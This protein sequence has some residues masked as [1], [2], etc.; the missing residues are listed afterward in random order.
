MPIADFIEKFPALDIPFPED[1]VSTKA[2]RSEDGLAVFFTFH[3]DLDLPAHAHKGQWGTVLT[4]EIE[5]TID[6]KTRTYRPGEAYSIPSGAVHSARIPAGTVVLDMF[7][8]PDRY[9]LRN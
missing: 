2:L 5:L 8:E 3:K 6:G 9:P 7:E 4:G 1:V